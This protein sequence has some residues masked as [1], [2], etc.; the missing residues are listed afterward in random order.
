MAGQNL[1]NLIQILISHE[2]E[3]LRSHC[4]S[5]AHMA[6]DR[7]ARLGPLGSESFPHR[8]EAYHTM[9]FHVPLVGTSVHLQALYLG[10]GELHFHGFRF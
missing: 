3:G 1:G 7:G 2:K 10:W 8:Q 5:K 6:V 4:W 9:C